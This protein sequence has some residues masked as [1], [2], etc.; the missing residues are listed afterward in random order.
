[1]ES[2]KLLLILI[3]ELWIFLAFGFLFLFIALDYIKKYKQGFGIVYV[4]GSFPKLISPEFGKV[5]NDR[6]FFLALQS[7]LTFLGA[8]LLLGIALIQIIAFLWIVIKPN[9]ILADRIVY[10]IVIVLSLAFSALNI[11]V[12]TLRT[13]MEQLNKNQT[14]TKLD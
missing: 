3:I 14:V 12:P 10:L 2:V 6:R 5:G 7:C 8:V 13:A 4:L 11:F 1:M 9:T